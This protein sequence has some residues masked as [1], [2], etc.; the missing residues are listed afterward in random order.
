MK[1][2]KLTREQDAMN[3][4]AGAIGTVFSVVSPD[5]IQSRL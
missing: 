4:P 1:E 2:T 3:H 5:V